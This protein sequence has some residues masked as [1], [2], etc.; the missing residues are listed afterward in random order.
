MFLWERWARGDL[1]L[2]Y[3]D[4]SRK[5]SDSKSSIPRFHTRCPRELVC[6]G[7]KDRKGGPHHR[8]VAVMHPA[9]SRWGGGGGWKESGNVKARAY[10]L[11]WSM[12][13]CKPSGFLMRWC[14]SQKQGMVSYML[15]RSFVL[16]S[17]IH[18]YSTE[19]SPSK[20]RQ[21]QNRRFLYHQT[22]F[23]FSWNATRCTRSSTF[24]NQSIHNLP[25]IVSL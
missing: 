13:A 23:L 17:Y 25:N 24:Q 2:P 3:C 22:A 6:F 10:T 16:Y 19:I 5:D 21:P 12:Q 7:V 4:H 18:S 8:P 11:Q 15:W 1:M 14:G 9:P 20:T